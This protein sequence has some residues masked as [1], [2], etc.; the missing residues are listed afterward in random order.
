MLSKTIDFL[1]QIRKKLNG[2]EAK[3]NFAQIA[4]DISNLSNSFE[5]NDRIFETDH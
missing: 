5:F 3:F 1:E 4:D 2:Q